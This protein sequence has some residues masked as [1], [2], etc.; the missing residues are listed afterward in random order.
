MK[1]INSSH[2]RY[3]LFF[4]II[5][6]LYHIPTMISGL[7]EPFIISKIRSS[8]QSTGFEIS[9]ARASYSLPLSFFAD[10]IVIRDTRSRNL[11]PVSLESFSFVL[12]KVIPP[13]TGEINLH[14]YQGSIQC[15]VASESK[16]PDLPYRYSCIVSS[17]SLT[18]H[19]LLFALGVE[20][21]VSGSIDG[22]V[23]QNPDLNN[24]NFSLTIQNGSI[25]PDKM[26]IS[27]VIKVPPFDSIDMEIRG[28]VSGSEIHITDG[29]MLTT[30]GK[31]S[32][33]GGSMVLRDGIL[34]DYKASGTLQLNQDGV[35]TIA[36]WLSLLAP[37]HEFTTSTSSFNVT[38]ILGQPKVLFGN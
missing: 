36:P 5:F 28:G 16:Y 7:V 12:T 23:H 14:G 10:A 19:P 2:R 3:L 24:A 34:S 26:L 15:S 4:I 21:I 38:S 20:G 17:I 1:S 30:Y 25:D 37:N 33:V 6:G 31:V 35:K 29:F 9:F 22:V 18:S 8:A 27:S 11:P 13:F 32:S